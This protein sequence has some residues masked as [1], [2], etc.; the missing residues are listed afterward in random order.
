MPAMIVR[1]PDRLVAAESRASS[2]PETAAT[3]F[4]SERRMGQAVR[5]GADTLAALI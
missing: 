2:N 4:S 5:S 1:R 3:P